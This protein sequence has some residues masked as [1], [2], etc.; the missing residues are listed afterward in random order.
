MAGPAN[1]LPGSTREKGKI[2]YLEAER[3]YRLHA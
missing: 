1:R 3:E 2:K